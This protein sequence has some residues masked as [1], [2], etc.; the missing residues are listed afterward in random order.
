MVTR[1]HDMPV[2]AARTHQI[3]APLYNLWRRAR[4][5]IKMPLRIDLSGMSHMV[6]IIE[7]DSW[8]VVDD[9]HDD[10]PILAWLDF[11][12]SG[13]SSLHTP[14]ECTLNYYHNM[15][16]KLRSQVLQ[17]ISD[18]LHTRLKNR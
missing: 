6:L 1:I 13:R 11:Q 18:V 4:L 12:D 15:A 8:V 3:D 14:V 2:Y 7:N 5:H 9:S 10:L 16:A 17:Q